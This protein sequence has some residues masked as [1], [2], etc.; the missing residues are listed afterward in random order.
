MPTARLPTLPA[1][2]WSSLKMF[3]G[4]PCTVR[5]KLNKFEHVGGGGER[6][7]PCTIGTPRPRVN[8]MTDMTENFTFP[9]AGGN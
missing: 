2:Y 7:R 6:L 4:S 5:A 9:L 1:L 8:R 3:W